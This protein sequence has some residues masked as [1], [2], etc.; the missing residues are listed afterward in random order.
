M[1]MLK[2]GS[3]WAIYAVMAAI[4]AAVML[5]VVGNPSFL[6]F[7]GAVVGGGAVL[8]AIVMKGAEKIGPS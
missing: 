3:F 4:V 8:A 2:T 5:F 7:V 6:A 1:E